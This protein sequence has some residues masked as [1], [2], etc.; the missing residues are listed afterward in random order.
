MRKGERARG[1]LRGRFELLFLSIV[2]GKIGIQV[3]SPTNDSNDRYFLKYSYTYHEMEVYKM[4][5]VTYYPLV[6]FLSSQN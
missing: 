4:R 1:G 3:K 2:A 5:N 6:F